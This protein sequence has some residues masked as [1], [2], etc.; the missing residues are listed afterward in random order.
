MSGDFGDHPL[1][2]SSLIGAAALI[3]TAMALAAFGRQ[4]DV[5]VTRMKPSTPVAV[6]MLRFDDG[7]DGSVRVSDVNGS[8][9][10]VVP[11]GTNGFLRGVLRGLARERRR[12]SVDALPPF[13]LTRWADGRLSLD[14]P[15]TGRHVDLE[16]FGPTNSAAF[17]RLFEEAG[18]ADPRIHL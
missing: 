11:P 9:V 14:D 1:P 15:A 6:R 17:A 7:A 8:T 13:R 18:R 5:G 4:Q 3:V 10:D 2:R 12:T 16:V